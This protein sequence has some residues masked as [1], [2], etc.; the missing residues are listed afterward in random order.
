MARSKLLSAS[1]GGVVAVLIQSP[2]YKFHTLADLEWLVGPSL[3]LQQFALLEGRTPDGANL[4]PVA[5]VL[6]ALV[7]AEVDARLMRELD[8]PIRLAPGEW[9]SGSIPWIVI[10]TGERKALPA[11]LEKLAATKFKDAP[12]K[13]RVVGADGRVSVGRLQSKIP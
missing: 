10:A 5:T 4:Y 6:W 1:L 2:D 7:S 12:P 8:R 9:R 11:L 13:L 3:A